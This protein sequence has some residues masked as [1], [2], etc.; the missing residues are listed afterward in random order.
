MRKARA[1]K[2]NQKEERKLAMITY[3]KELQNDSET[4]RHLILKEK[5]SKE[6][7][8]KWAKLDITPTNAPSELMAQTGPKEFKEELE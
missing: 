8:S 2:M 1:F 5:V 4:V 7:R 6:T 3:D